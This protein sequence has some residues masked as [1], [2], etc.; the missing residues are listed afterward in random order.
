ME[1]QS[2]NIVLFS[3][4]SFL[5]LS[6]IAFLGFRAIEHEALLDKYEHR[7]L[8][9]THI[10]QAETFIE[11]QLKQKQVRVN[12]MVSF[13]SFDNASLAELTEKDTDIVAAFILANNQLIYPNERSFL[14]PKQRDWLN[15][16]APIIEDPSRLYS[17][18]YTEEA[19]P[20]WGW[21]QTEQRGEPVLIYWLKQDNQLLGFKISYISLL[22][23]LLGGLEMAVAPD[24]LTI[25]DN[26]ALIYQQGQAALI[27]N[28]DGLL[29]S[30]LL[31]YPLNFWQVNYYTRVT[32]SNHSVYLWGSM[33]VGS[34]IAFIGMMMFRYYRRYE[35][36]KQHIA[37]QERL[38]DYLSDT[39]ARP[40]SN[41]VRQ[42]RELKQIEVD[43][44]LAANQVSLL[45]RWRNEG[46]AIARRADN[47][48][49]L[50]ETQ[51]VKTSQFDL[52]ELLRS[53]S[54]DF[55]SLYQEKGM[56]IHLMLPPQL[57]VT[58]D[59]EKVRLILANLLC[60]AEKYAR[61][62]KR[63]DL[64]CRIDDAQQQVVVVIRDYGTGVSGVELKQLFE[65]FYRATQA[66]SDDNIGIGVGLTVS[67]YL[68]ESLGG[69]LQ[70]DIKQPGLAFILRLPVIH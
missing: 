37:Q 4:I 49:V 7:E 57:L 51:P 22:T 53:L 68:A 52:C 8:A 47:L 46:N 62:G 1:K 65:P 36:N 30:S 24:A 17:H 29:Q 23:D 31:P 61:L 10:S 50:N 26:G 27:D 48:L 19:I 67:R 2:K 20:D 13:M 60:N 21:Y 70:A 3:L 35:L 58:S 38:I 33:L 28:K 18:A 6:F 44:P 43:K 9:R 64:S 39:I 11:H 45:N 69:S 59:S 34:L 56:S 66:V 12:S 14:S 63:V 16:L 41:L 40:V 15:V 25:E 42:M 54:G 5:V 32:N 55:Q